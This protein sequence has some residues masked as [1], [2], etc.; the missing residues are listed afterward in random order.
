MHH[1]HISKWENGDYSPDSDNIKKLA[2]ALGVPMPEFYELT[3]YTGQASPERTEQV[4]ISYGEDKEL[5]LQY[6]STV[7]HYLHSQL[8]MVNDEISQLERP[9]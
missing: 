3:A 6:L 4:P 9:D 1:T 5:R 7:R 8:V 2:T